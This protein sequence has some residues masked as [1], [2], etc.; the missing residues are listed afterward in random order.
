MG[1]AGLVVLLLVV[2]ACGGVDEGQVAAAAV[3]AAAESALLPEDRYRVLGV[4]VDGGCAAVVVTERAET[5]TSRMTAFMADRD[6]WEL[7]DYMVGDESVRLDGG[8][9]ECRR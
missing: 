2:V 9:E 7:V 1:R 3:S 6:G 8:R 5:R 4:A